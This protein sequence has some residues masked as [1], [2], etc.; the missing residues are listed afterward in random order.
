MLKSLRS[1]A[2]GVKDVLPLSKITVSI[3]V[4]TSQP[5]LNILQVENTIIR[6]IKYPPSVRVMGVKAATDEEEIVAKVYGVLCAQELPPLTHA[7]Y[8]HCTTFSIR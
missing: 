5:G 7:P 4:T 6:K 1:R 2:E 3:I 8:V